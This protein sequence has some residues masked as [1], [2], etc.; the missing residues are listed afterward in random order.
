M[1]QEEWIGPAII[2]A[3]IAGVFSL[4]GWVMAGSR[5]RASERRRRAERRVDVQ[6]ALKAEIQHYVD[7]LENPKFDPDK[8]WEVVV[9]EMEEN[10]DYVPL[11][12]SERNDTLFR[13]ILPE[14]HVLPEPVI[15]PVVRYY[16]Q[17]FAIEAMI[18]D[19][20]GGGF[21][22]AEQ[23]QRIKM[24]TDYISLKLGALDQGREALDALARS[25]A[26][27]NSPGAARSGLR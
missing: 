2:A 1:L 14:I 27:V 23:D 16:N 17:V 24:Y 25:L 20:R 4:L 9:S 22:T 3:L 21:A 11:I 6:T 19:L 8:V 10:E 15:K 13:A 7:I 26:D 5:E 18:A 12:P